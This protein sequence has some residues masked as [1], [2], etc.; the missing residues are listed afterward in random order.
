MHLQ[1]SREPLKNSQN[2]QKN[3]TIPSFFTLNL[4][5]R[6]IQGGLPLGH[7]YPFHTQQIGKPCQHIKSVVRCFTCLLALHPYHRKIQF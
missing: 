4:P 1:V 5:N 7:Q 2:F 3:P 6:Q